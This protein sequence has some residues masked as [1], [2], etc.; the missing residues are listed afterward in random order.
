MKKGPSL[1]A[2]SDRGDAF[3]QLAAGSLS[4]SSWPSQARSLNF[5]KLCSIPKQPLAGTWKC[6]VTVSAAITKL[7]GL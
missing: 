5:R 2:H 7:K 3:S 4:A 1:A 6:I